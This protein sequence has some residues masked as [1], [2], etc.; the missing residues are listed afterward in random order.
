[1]AR[2]AVKQP[3]D[4]LLQERERIGFAAGDGVPGPNRHHGFRLHVYLLV[5]PYWRNHVSETGNEYF[6]EN[7]V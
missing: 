3:V 1:M 4:F 5:K 6:D 7:Q 2:H